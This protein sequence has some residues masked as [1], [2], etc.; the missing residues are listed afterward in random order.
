MSVITYMIRRADPATCHGTHIKHDPLWL[1]R[2][3]LDE[4]G[5]IIPQVIFSFA[6]QPPHSFT[7]AG[8][9]PQYRLGT[10]LLNRPGEMHFLLHE[11][12]L[13]LDS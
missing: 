4:L 8:I 7:I 6:I 9:P 12:D 2:L 11:A 1:T 10:I 5:P 13:I 3:Y